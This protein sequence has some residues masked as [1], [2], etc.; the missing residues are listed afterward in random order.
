MRMKVLWRKSIPEAWPPSSI[1]GSTGRRLGIALGAIGALWLGVLWV[2]L[3][4][5]R[6]AQL[7][8]A[9]IPDVVGKQQAPQSQPPAAVSQ[10]VGLR[11]LVMAG[12][13]TGLN[14]SFD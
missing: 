5:P 14:G 6:E 8:S 13:P 2:M 4:L 9:P 10:R 11:S 12:D 7:A 3:T 1:L